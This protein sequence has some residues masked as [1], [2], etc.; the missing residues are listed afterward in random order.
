MG[1]RYSP[2]SS[3]RRKPFAPAIAEQLAEVGWQPHEIRLIAVTR[4]PGSFTGL[5]VGVTA[6]KVLAYAAGADVIGVNTLEA[7]AWQS[8]GELSD[9]CVVMDAQRKQVFTAGFRRQP[10][11]EPSWQPIQPTT[12]VDNQQWL[13]SLDGKRAV[14]GPGLVRLAQQVPDGVPIVD[15][16]CWAPGRLRSGWSPIDTTATVNAMTCGSFRP[17][18]IARACG[19]E[20]RSGTG[21]SMKRGEKP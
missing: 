7:I 16:A 11:G 10:N 13:Q 17:T 4:G 14:T 3:V 1:N 21:L 5:R 2:T 20:T 15:E 8:L 6:A 9:V 12:I 19:R 18:T